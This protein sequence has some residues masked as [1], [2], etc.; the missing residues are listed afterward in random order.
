MDFELFQSVGQQTFDNLR[1]FF[2]GVMK[3]EL[4]NKEIYYMACVC[5]RYNA[6][7]DWLIVI[8]LQGI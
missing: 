7:Y 5:T 8:E 6:R 4:C 3:G 1:P 2:S